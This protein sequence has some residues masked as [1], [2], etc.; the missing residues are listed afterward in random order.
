L[1]WQFYQRKSPRRR[2]SPTAILV[3]GPAHLIRFRSVISAAAHP[4]TSMHLCAPGASIDGDVVCIGDGEH[5][6]RG[7]CP[8]HFA[9]SLGFAVLEWIKRITKLRSYGPDRQA[10]LGSRRG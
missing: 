5:S 1:G 4:V 7:P 9:F 6:D 2:W 10:H 3:L 8:G